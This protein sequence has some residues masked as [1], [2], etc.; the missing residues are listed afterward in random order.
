MTARLPIPG[1]DDGTWGDILNGYNS[2]AVQNV[3][4]TRRSV[5]R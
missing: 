5:V 1:S 3:I 4:I 2:I